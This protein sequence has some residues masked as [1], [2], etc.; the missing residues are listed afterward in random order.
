MS[1]P[2]SMAFQPIVHS[3][4]GAIYAYEALVRGLNGEGAPAVMSGIARHRRYLFDHQC[5]LRAIALAHRLRLAR[6]GACL[7]INVMPNAVHEPQVGLRETLAAA[8]QVGFPLDR[9]IL[10][11]TEDEKFDA[12][13]IL[14]TLRA[15]RHL[16]FKTA[17]D[18]FGSGH[19]GLSL[20]SRF[21]PD[22]VKLDMSLIRD[23]DS[24]PV[25]RSIVRHMVRLLDERGIVSLAEGVETD[26]ELSTLKTLGVTLIQGFLIARPAFEALA[27][28]A[29]RPRQDSNLQPSA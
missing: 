27:A 16:G 8:E 5:R 12:P 6:G 3:A 7:S 2:F 20:L 15:Y 22:I 19:S 10:E 13:H 4:T 14:D 21:Q 26:E 29:W 1:A 11:F 24:V 9:I 28:P 23:I 25:K 17:I 18:D